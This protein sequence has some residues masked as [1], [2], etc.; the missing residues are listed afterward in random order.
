[1]GKIEVA[2]VISSLQNGMVKLATSLKQKKYRDKEGLFL[3]EGVR[4][5]EDIVSVGGEI[6]AVL[7]DAELQNER[8]E[9]LLSSLDASVRRI[10]VTPEVYRKIQA[11]EESQGIVAIVKQ[12][13]WTLADIAGGC[14]HLAVLDRVQDP[15]NIG[16][17][18]RTSEA[19]GWDGVLVLRGSADI[20]SPKV[21]RST[22]GTMLHLP[23]VRGL[24]E[25]EL[26]NFVR[27]RAIRLYATS[28]VESKT[29]DDCD[30]TQS[31]AVVFGNEGAG[32]SEALLASADERIH[33]PLY[34]RVE[35]INVAAA[36]AVICFEGTRQKQIACQTSETV[37]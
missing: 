35:S 2:E 7:Y 11:T 37:L 23:V 28:V 12:K 10:A 5:V 14:V 31:A 19:A 9:V 15:G 13:K 36:A 26:M 4:I 1:M 25:N 33:I 27:E 20:Y 21:V 24:D 34:G 32:V 6:Q 16:T 18:I 17:I 3:A 8:I 30:F 29:Y 22:M